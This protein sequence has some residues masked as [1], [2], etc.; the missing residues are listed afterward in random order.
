MI[1]FL[2]GTLVEAWPNRIVLD[3]GG[4]GYDVFVSFNTF[5]S[6]PAL[7]QQI[8]LLTHLQ[9]REDE[10][11][12]FGFYTVEERDLFKMLVHHVSGVGPKVAL[13]ML[14]G[15]SL[16]DLRKAVVQGDIKFLSQLKGVGKKTAERIVMELRDKVGVSEAW[17]A[18][19]SPALSPTQHTQNDAL[20]ALIALGYKQAD[21]ARVL[22][23]IP[24][25]G[26]VEELV[27]EALKKI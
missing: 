6:L 25:A 15:C 23:A 4:V 27:R 21:A 1:S 14:G 12:L 13:A 20:L 8:K 17:A 5:N 7:G 9:V 16:D 19:A 18:A 10:H 2:K 24:V 26:T 22:K 3:V 11:L